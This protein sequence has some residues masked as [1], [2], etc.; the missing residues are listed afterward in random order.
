MHRLSN[1]VSY[2]SD[3]VVVLIILGGFQ[4]AS[5]QNNAP[6]QDSSPKSDPMAE[7]STAEPSGVVP[8]PERR[9][10]EQ[11]RTPRANSSGPVIGPGDEVEVTVYGAPDLS[12]H[13]R[14]SAD[15]NIS[16]SLIGSV[17][18]GGLSSSE[19]EG[20]IEVSL[21]TRYFLASF[22]NFPSGPRATSVSANISYYDI[23]E[24]QLGADSPRALTGSFESDP[25]ECRGG[26]VAGLPTRELSRRTTRRSVGNGL[27]S[28]FSSSRLKAVAQ[29]PP[30]AGV[31]DAPACRG[32]GRGFARLRPHN[33]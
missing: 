4:V 17:R 13:T 18:V 9:S 27:A 16:I 14:V 29:L 31:A 26:A 10:P 33:E 15:G 5:A 3:L 8:P 21:K 1:P 2:L 23:Y 20:A 19:A 32:H 6:T 7:P 30:C 25:I 12:K 11:E 24:D 28:S 22:R